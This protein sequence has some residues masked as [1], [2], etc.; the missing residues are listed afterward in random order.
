MRSEKV[1]W[2]L[3]PLWL[4]QCWHPQRGLALSLYLCAST[5]TQK[6]GQADAAY[7]LLICCGCFKFQLKNEKHLDGIPE[8]GG[9]ISSLTKCKFN[10]HVLNLKVNSKLLFWWRKKIL[11]SFFF[12]PPLP[13]LFF[14]FWYCWMDLLPGGGVRGLCDLTWPSPSDWVKEGVGKGW[15]VQPGKITG[16]SPF[17]PSSCAL[18]PC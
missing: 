2:I 7:S 17:L 16:E 9:E 8:R 13:F 4:L 5:S 3:F 14:F 6:S 12:S 10:H 1:L 18:A 11:E 15:G